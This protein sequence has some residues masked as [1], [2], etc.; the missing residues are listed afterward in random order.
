MADQ[1]AGWYPDPLGD[2]TKL[3]YWN[4][5]Q[6]TDD[7]MDAPQEYSAQ[8]QVGATE[9]NYQSDS[10][11]NPEM[12]STNQYAAYGNPTAN[13]GYGDPSVNQTYS[14]DPSYNQAYNNNPSVNQGYNAS[15]SYNQAYYYQQPVQTAVNDNE[16]TMKLIAFILCIIS[17][18]TIGWAII[19]LAWMIPMTVR[20]WGIYQ[21]T[22]PNTTAFAVCTLIFVTVIGGILLL[23]CK[24][25]K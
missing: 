2:T 23:V 14:S 3:R 4:G 8:T 9:N 22:K 6:W 10:A 16:Q 19:P 17:T 21:G 13:P 18:V 20:C 24:R 15:P 7:Y 11:Y 5:T 25:E 12:N 1:Q